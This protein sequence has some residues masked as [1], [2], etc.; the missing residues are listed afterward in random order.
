MADF[1]VMTGW[2]AEHV[3]HLA[4]RAGFGV[5]PERAAE[6]AAQDPATVVAA[7]VDGTGLEGARAAFTAALGRADPVDQPAAGSAPDRVDPIPGPHRYL[8]DGPDAWRSELGRAQG[9]L[10]FRMQYSPDAMAE[11]MAL[12]WHNL[13]ATG[14]AKVGSIPLMLQHYATLRDRGLERFEELHAAVSKDPAMTVWL[15]GILNR[16]DAPNENYAR[17]AM[18]LFSL[19]ADNHYTQH[20]ITEL[21]KALSGWSY[22]VESQDLVTDPTNPDRKVAARGT[23][24]VWDG[25][26]L[27][28]GE[29][30]Q[31]DLTPD[32]LPTALPD[33]RATG[34]VTFLDRTFTD[35]NAPVDGQ[36]AGEQV[37][38]SILSS[39]SAEASRFL[40]GRLA[41]HFV[42]GQAAEADLSQLAGKIV[43]LGF[44][45]RAVMK[46]L[47]ASRWF[48]DDANRFALVEGPVSWMVRAARALG[49]GL[50]AAAGATA[51]TNRFP[52][53]AEICNPWDTNAFDL[54]GMRLLDPAGPN[55]WKEDVLWLNSNTI[56]YRT[57]VAAALALGE[58][59]RQDGG[60]DRVIFPTE[61]AE[62]FPVAPASPAEVLARLTALLQPAPIPAAV[63]AD[64]LGRLWPA[65]FTWD[66]GSRQKARELAFLVL[67]SPSAQV[68]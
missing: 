8:V 40:A 37:L 30:L 41:L 59:F 48:Y 46:L 15:D 65:A 43:E 24:R 38:R 39:R 18:E 58:T 60:A 49:A 3:E 64:W 44:D 51:A 68:Y 32:E 9:Y 42:T 4:R 53:W 54:A 23:F 34:G 63:Q 14:Q 36:V 6:L 17:E 62:W 28:R 55:G 19:G 20:D 21:A 35:L 16:G 13:F 31:W 7:W 11:R 45:M 26:P 22:V 33:W 5:T 47:L 2:T 67:C 10:A 50:G 27:T 57:K 25:S 1:G 29:R 52:A 56:R 61:P 12:F 66:D